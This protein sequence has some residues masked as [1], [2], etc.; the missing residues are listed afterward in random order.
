MEKLKGKSVKE[1][2]HLVGLD[3]Y[4]ETLRKKVDDYKKLHKEVNIENQ[5]IRNLITWKK[6][7]YINVNTHTGRSN[8]QSANNQERN[9]NNSRCLIPIPH[10]SG[11]I[12]SNQGSNRD[13]PRPVQRNYNPTQQ[14]RPNPQ[15]IAAYQTVVPSQNFPKTPNTQ[16]IPAQP[17]VSTPLSHTKGQNNL[18]LG[19]VLPTKLVP[20]T[21]KEHRQKL[22]VEKE[23]AKKQ[24]PVVQVAYADN[25]FRDKPKLQV[26]LGKSRKQEENK[27]SQKEAT[28][29]SVD[30]SSPRPNNQNSSAVG[31]KSKIDS[32]IVSPQIRPSQFIRDPRLNKNLVGPSTSSEASSSSAMIS[33]TPKTGSNNA[34]QKIQQQPTTLIEKSTSSFATKDSNEIKKNLQQQ[35]ST[36]SEKSSLSTVK[37]GFD[38]NKKNSQK[39]SSEKPTQPN[40]KILK[41]NSNP[42]KKTSTSQSQLTEM[43]D[44][45]SKQLELSYDEHRKRKAEL[46]KDQ[47][48]FKK[49][50][51]NKSDDNSQRSEKS[52]PPSPSNSSN[53]L[54]CFS[55]LVPYS[56]SAS[57][58]FSQSI[59]AFSSKAPNERK[60]QI[61]M[62]PEDNEEINNDLLD[63]KSVCSDSTD[64][65]TIE[66]DKIVKEPVCNDSVA[67]SGYLTAVKN[68]AIERYSPDALTQILEGNDSFKIKKEEEDWD[69]S[70]STDVEKMLDAQSEVSS[71]SESENDKKDPNFSEEFLKKIYGDSEF[72]K[73]FGIALP[74]SSNGKSHY[75]ILINLLLFFI[76]PL[77]SSKQERI[78]EWLAFNNNDDDEN[79]IDC[80]YDFPMSEDYESE[81]VSAI[82]EMDIDVSQIIS[83]EPIIKN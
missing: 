79:S 43:G 68:E 2:K 39:P 38:S 57:S 9:Q 78:Q 15:N 31:S 76:V 8:Y 48:N 50:R 7:R 37:G 73:I 6:P 62:E 58:L 47:N 18:T 4:F 14:H 66:Y 75:F 69:G 41:E 12:S 42:I 13:S 65:D 20:S 83:F 25:S 5:I 17:V 1:L 72:H 61:K 11:V 36:S 74:L 81:N 27:S 60:I 45:K 44:S 51:L 82:D 28:K 46:E 53:Q 30:K 64:D 24:I 35:P 56:L 63:Q 33:H 10:Y 3:I 22:S 52:P 70:A 54:E 49:I 55:P 77:E 40:A 34:N 26:C 71:D 80:C 21:Y 29:M 59:T 32:S 67:S 23:A 16:N 19:V